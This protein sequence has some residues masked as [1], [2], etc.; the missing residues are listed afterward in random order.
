MIKKSLQI[1][2]RNISRP[3]GIDFES[4]YPVSDYFGDDRGTPVD[5]LYIDSFLKENRS[6]VRGQ[7]LEVAEDTYSRKY[8]SGVTKFD[9]LHYE[10]LP[11]ATLVG[12][13]SKPET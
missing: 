9:V 3:R 11:G 13:L 5:R 4:V 7:V 8:G 2:K 1:L 6:L 12:D 10:A